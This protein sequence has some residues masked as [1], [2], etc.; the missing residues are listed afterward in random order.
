MVKVK[1]SKKKAQKLE[2]KSSKSGVFQQLI[3]DVGLEDWDAVAGS[4]DE[5]LTSHKDDLTYIQLVAGAKW[6]LD[7]RNFDLCHRLAN[8]GLSRE[9][10]RP[11]SPEVL[12][13]LHLHWGN[14]ALAR[15]SLTLARNFGGDK[16]QYLI[17]EV[18]LFNEE[19]NH[20]AILEL[21][22]ADRIPFAQ[23]DP[24]LSEI[25]F[26]VVIAMIATNRTVEARDVVDKFFPESSISDPNI[27]NLHAKINQAEENFPEAVRCFELVETKYDGE[28]VAIEA[29][30]NKS[31][32]QLSYGDLVNGWKNYEVRWKWNQFPTRKFPFSAPW[33]EG[34]RLAGK[35]ILLWGEQGI[36][37]EILFL[38][39]L[40]ELLKLGPAKVGICASEKICPVIE[41]WYPD[42][43]VYSF[44]ADEAFF[45][46]LSFDY[47]LPSG[48]LPLKLGNQNVSGLKH[49][50]ED[51]PEAVFLRESILSKYPGKSRVIGLSWRSGALSLKRIHHY[52]SHKAMLELVREAPDDI[53][54]VSLQYGIKDEEISDLSLASNVYIPNEDFF[55]D[56]IAQTTHI[57]A[58][59]LILTSGSVCLALAG[60]TAKPCI[61][62]GPKRG[63]TLLGAEK[64]PWFPLVHLIKCEPNWDLGALI[65]QMKKLLHIFY[66]S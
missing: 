9:P 16:P 62:W 5:L 60:I 48:S 17:W 27:M 13:F 65:I 52:I 21:Y 15:S 19:G 2:K 7:S 24:R 12:F 26:S 50:I 18:L 44:R 6:M 22:D 42:V 34:E 58:C 40:P 1:K 38:T 3:K 66:Q 37:D 25:V 46:E 64:Y 51:S 59:D 10:E 20:S 61:T 39:L 56:L 47:Q 33:W 35:S 31:L 32:L 63:W 11:E 4:L 28:Q 36:G 41:K 53:L 43:A 45:E 8:E 23:D 49:F 30:W 55:D 29:R 57:Q 14:V 54:F